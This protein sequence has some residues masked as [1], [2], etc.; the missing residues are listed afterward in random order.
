MCL[1]SRGAQLRRGPGGAQ[2]PQLLHELGKFFAEMDVALQGFEHPSLYRVDVWDIRNAPSTI[3]QH[4][5]SETEIRCLGSSVP[6]DLHLVEQAANSRPLPAVS[7]MCVLGIMLKDHVGLMRR[8]CDAH[9]GHFP[10]FIPTLL[11]RR[12]SLQ[13]LE[14]VGEKVNAKVE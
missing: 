6:S 13:E 11:L 3:R 10:L 2:S 4:L 9:V 7:R 8:S 5:P 12:D 14:K 1:I